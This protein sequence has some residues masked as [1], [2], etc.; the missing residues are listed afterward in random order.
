MAR[1]SSWVRLRILERRLAREEDPCLQAIFRERIERE[2]DRFRRRLE[3]TRRMRL[4]ISNKAVAE[5]LGVPKGTVDAG[6]YKIA[7]RLRDYPF[8]SENG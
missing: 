6:M 8:K 7:K 5:V 1:D 2:R 4:T 3:E